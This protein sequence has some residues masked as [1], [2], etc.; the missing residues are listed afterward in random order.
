ML[1][2]AELKFLI[3][4]GTSNPRYDAVMRHRIRRK[5]LTF[6]REDLP[7]LKHSDWTARWLRELLEITE[8]CNGISEFRKVG[9]NENSPNRTPF[10]IKWCGRR[11]SNPRR[12]LG[13]LVS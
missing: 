12:E 8:N 4:G 7:A 10:K 9:E 11:D 3:E 1:S 5:L 2:K 6:Q 13:K